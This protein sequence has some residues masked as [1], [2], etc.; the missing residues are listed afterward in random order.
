[1][2][3]Y[4]PFY[5]P[6]VARGLYFRARSLW[7]EIDAQLML[8]WGQRYS[9]NSANRQIVLRH[10]ALVAKARELADELRAITV[11]LA[12]HAREKEGG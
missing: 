1:M 6:D 12:E 2:T 9:D 11:E 7:D 4:T 8:P 5:N 10:R 3:K